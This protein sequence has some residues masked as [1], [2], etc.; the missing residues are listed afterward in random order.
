MIGTGNKRELARRELARRELARRQL[1]VFT[2]YTFP[3]Y[4]VGGAHALLGSYLE[5]VERYVASGGQEGIGRL[6]VFE[7]PRHGKSELVSVRFPAWFLGRNPDM[8]VI[9]A[10]CT[11]ELAVGF[12]RRVRNLVRDTPFQN[13][14]GGRAGLRP[15]E[16]VRLAEDTQAVEEWGLAGHRGGLKAAGV[17]GAII[18]RGAK[19]A[20]IDDPFRDRKDAESKATRDAVDDWYRSTLYTRVEDGG[21]IVLMHQRWH[22]DDLAGRLLRRMVTDEG[23]DQWVI[24]CLPAVAEEWARTETVDRRAL[25]E[26]W[27]KGPDPLGR[28]PGEVLWERKYPAAALEGIRANIGGYEWDALYQQRPRRM[29]GTLIRAYEIR[30]VDAVGDPAQGGARAEGDAR[31]VRYWDLAVSGRE[32]ADYICGARVGYRAADGRYRIMDVRR[33]RGP[34]AD[35]RGAMK[36]VMLADGAEVPQGIEVA[37]QQAGYFQELQRDPDLQ[38]RV[39]VAVNPQQAGNKEVRAQV[40]ASRIPDGLIEMVEAG[41]ND[42]FIAECLAFPRGQYDDQVDGVSGAFQ[43]LTTRMDVQLGF[44]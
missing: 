23:A 17:G 16:T 31:E 26:G 41:W 9:E 1:M 14:F 35:A 36:A 7:P 27:W 29:E 12:S 3:Q 39:L 22:A 30:I 5:Q 4:V 38:G 25:Q 43:M 34:W 6:M 13:V 2:C 20:I 28:A 8:P 24:L 15:E 42:A 19:L 32:T 40:W 37:G 33:M 11:A 10:S 18:G 44:A 21:A